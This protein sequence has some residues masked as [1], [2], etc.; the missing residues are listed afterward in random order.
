MNQ[1][2]EA[3]TGTLPWT[4]S[5]FVCGIDNPNGLH[6]RSR[7]EDSRVVLDYTT[8][9]T[10]LGYRHIV[11]GGI[12]MTLLDEV[13]TWAAIVSC[14]RACVAAEMSTRLRKPVVVGQALRVEGWVTSARAR[15]ILTEGRIVDGAGLELMAASGKYMP[16]PA[17]QAFLCSK[18][19]VPDA[20]TIDPAMLLGEHAA[21]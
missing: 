9:E 20:G 4:R 12:G 13:M 15:L 17:D 11:H 1:S 21:P 14:R 6:L 8:R 5:C 19:F 18:D 7:V 2:K 16:M 10:D 3:V